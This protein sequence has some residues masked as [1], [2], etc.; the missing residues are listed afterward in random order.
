MVFFLR[1]LAVGLLVSSFFIL[2]QA[3]AG[4][5]EPIYKQLKDPTTGGQ[6]STVSMSITPDGKK[7]FVLSHASNK[8]YIYDLTTPF[9]LSTMDVS[10]R[11]VV[12][13]VGDGGVNIGVNDLKDIEFNNDGTKVFVFDHDGALLIHNLTTPYDVA[14]I[15]SS[16][17]VPDDGLNYNTA[18]GT[19]RIHGVTFNNDGTKMYLSDG[20]INST[21]ITQ[22]NLSTPFDPSSGTSTYN[23][24]TESIITARYTMDLAFD[25]DG[26]R[27]Y[28]S[29]SK[30]GVDINYMHV[31]KLSNP[32]ELSSAT[33]V[34]KWQILGNG[35]NLSPYAWTFGNNGMKL[36]IGTED[37]NADGDN[38]IYEY[39]LSCPYGIVLCESETSSV[40]S[41]QVEIAKN[42]IHQNTSTIFKRFEWIRRNENKTNL[43]SHNL[44]LNINN[45]ILASL[46]NELQ[47]S[48]TSS[49]K[50]VKYTQASL[51][52]EKPAENKR[53]WSH[54]SNADISFG[55]VG[56]TISLK[57]KEITTKGIS[58]GADRLTKNDNFFG[59]AVRYG[60]DDI[61]IKS[62]TN[63]ELNSQSLSFNVYSQLPVNEKSNLNALLGVSFLS[64]DQMTS[65][66]ITGERNGKQIYT[67]LSYEE[68]QNYTKF[69]II[70]YG[71]AELGI[72]Q[73]S[74]YTDFGTSSTNN[75]E[76]H[77]RLTFKTGNAS[78]G[79]KFD[80]IV[81][82]DE[83]RISRN[84]FLEY[85]VD[86]TPDIDHRYKNHIDSVTVQNTIKRYSLNNIKGN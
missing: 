86:F 36:Y 30:V 31:W 70:P 69:D 27:L 85:V 37:P 15:S 1:K 55:R 73:L 13:F 10:N 22:V 12:D 40:A 25:D 23:L 19:A 62:A 71:K 81:D 8:Y 34:D 11:S 59:F 46:K 78:A 43:N 79:F 41:A 45:P 61:D 33:Y 63:E 39:D 51:K 68:E 49:F 16:T 2:M 4:I 6:P 53:K 72:T 48:F 5:V 24:D 56:D 60:N 18:Y 28:L 83:S 32:F 82:M 66:T 64:I 54:W 74:E 75:I 47:S 76:T 42:V 58:F 52:T 84:G 21:D 3:Q 65:G 14:S 57:P 7:M 20:T 67:A 44:K 35:N 26:T 50:D 80:Q 38:I 9:D 77:E 29:E 17:A